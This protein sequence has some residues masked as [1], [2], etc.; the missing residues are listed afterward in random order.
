MICDTHSQ[1]ELFDSTH[2]QLNDQLCK[3]N[4]TVSGIKV[5]LVINLQDLLQRED[6]IIENSKF[7]VEEIL[8]DNNPNTD[9]I[10][11]N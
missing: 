11:T 4:E 7:E 5:P 2:K 8:D 10:K 6:I 9:A 1:Q 3:C